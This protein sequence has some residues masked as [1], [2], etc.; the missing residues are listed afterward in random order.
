M[1]IAYELLDM[2]IIHIDFFFFLLVET[3]DFTEKKKNRIPL[4]FQTRINSM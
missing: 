3:K 4:Y 2:K 1:K